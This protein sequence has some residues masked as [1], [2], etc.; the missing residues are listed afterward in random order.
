MREKDY[1][2]TFL[3][4]LN[5]KRRKNVQFV[6]TL[7]FTHYRDIC[8]YADRKKEKKESVTVSEGH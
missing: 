3:T 4:L 7:T 1:D 5:H 8:R 2:L 6:G